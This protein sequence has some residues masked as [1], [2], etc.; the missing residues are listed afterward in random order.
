MPTKKTPT[1]SPSAR[2]IMQ[3]QRRALK[4]SAERAQEQARERA[5]EEW[6]RR[7]ALHRDR[8]SRA[9]SAVHN[10]FMSTVQR[11]AT[12]VA[13]TW[14]VNLPTYV[15]LGHTLVAWTDFTS[16]RVEYPSK[17]QRGLTDVDLAKEGLVNL[18]A[19]SARA[20]LAE[21]RG[22]IYHE[23]GHVRFTIPLPNLTQHLIENQHD[24]LR[25]EWHALDNKQYLWNLLED[26]RM[27]ARVV[28]DSPIIGTYLTSVIVNL[29][30]ATPML[31]AF[32]A[33]RRF[34]PEDL[35]A[36]ARAEFVASYGEQTAVEVE[37]VIARYSSA[38]THVEL[39]EAVIEFGSV[40]NPL[41]PLY[42]PDTGNATHTRSR[43]DDKS[44]EDGATDPQEP[45]GGSQSDPEDADSDKG[46]SGDEKASEGTQKASEGT[47]GDEGDQGDQGGASGASGGPEGQSGGEDES[48]A[49]G[50]QGVGKSLR[51]VLN[52]SRQ[53]AAEAL[54]DQA[55]Q[56][57]SLSDA[58]DHILDEAQRVFSGELSRLNGTAPLTGTILDTAESV[59]DMLRESF[60]T[61][62]AACAPMWQHRVNRGV[63]DPFAYRTREP[64][65]QDFRRQY[66][67]NGD[68][69]RSLAVSLLLDTSGS[70]EGYGE[71]LGAAAFATA[72]ACRALDIPITV[73]T[74]DS[75][76][77]LLYGADDVD[78]EAT[79]LRCSGGTHPGDSLRML[80]DQRC[81]KQQHIA[82][83]LTD[84]MWDS[85]DR[86]LLRQA[87]DDVDGVFVLGFN[88]HESVL[89]QFQ[90]ATEAHSL[91]DLWDLPI[92][93][94]SLVNER[95]G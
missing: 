42:P 45:Q 32:V 61:T 53:Q 60:D 20:L 78:I 54:A 47:Q 81:D 4:S 19:E 41:L 38:R 79:A 28:A 67:D 50:G 33:G 17:F 65:S 9:I 44:P 80:G 37:R 15:T 36:A 31:W 39:V 63:I 95:L 58:I 30:E 57:A 51:Q 76:A 56:D 74:F 26:Q 85:H 64:G 93:V 24:A 86:D 12:A 89:N 2:K 75:Y 71:Q 83:I 25:E 87:C 72:T 66:T 27:E 35:R 48:D 49:S 3:A 46:D 52:E 10:G 88:L 94:Q 34:L 84:G 22:V 90:M 69:G 73:L 8:G 1:L 18:D 43:S 6:V 68:L 70:M 11:M 92:I 21:I 77:R 62:I 14:G 40:L 59:A 13:S 7:Q 16:I 5:R 29:F 91:R 23:V 82:I 55:A